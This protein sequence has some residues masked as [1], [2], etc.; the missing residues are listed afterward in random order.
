[1]AMV[2]PCEQDELLNY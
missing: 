1:M 2:T